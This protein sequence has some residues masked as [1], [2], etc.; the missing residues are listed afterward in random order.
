[1]LIT[2]KRSKEHPEICYFEPYGR[3]THA[4]CYEL[5]TK[6]FE[7]VARNFRNF[8]LIVQRE[9][10]IDPTVVPMLLDIKQEAENKQSQIVMVLARTEHP[11]RNYGLRVFEAQRDA[12]LYHLEI[13]HGRFE[14]NIDQRVLESESEFNQEVRPTS[15]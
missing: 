5:L 4:A 7:L 2:E 13:R 14:T 8:T 10:L 11:H 12:D 6:M 3:L 15:K 9:S 1:M